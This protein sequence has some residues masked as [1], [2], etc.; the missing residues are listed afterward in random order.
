MESPIKLEQGKQVELKSPNMPCMYGIWNMA[1]TRAISIS[2]LK[3][4]S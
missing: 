2:V 4:I 3:S 1:L